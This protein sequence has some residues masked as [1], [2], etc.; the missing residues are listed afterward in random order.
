M[1]KIFGTNLLH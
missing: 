1:L